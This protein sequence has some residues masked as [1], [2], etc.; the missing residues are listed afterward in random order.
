MRALT[1]AMTILAFPWGSA[2]A[3]EGA[4]ADGN[5]A[6]KYWQAFATLPKFTDAENKKISECVSTPLDHVTSKML[7]DAEYSFQMLHRGASLRRCDWGMSYEQGIYARFPHT[8]AARV[9]TSLAVLR[10]RMRFAAGQNAEATSDLL[11][12]MT[13]GRHISVD[14]SIITVLVGYQ[15]DNRI[16][17][18][19]AQN[20]PKL[21]AKSI[22]D[23]KNRLDALPSFG[24]MSAALLTCEKETMEW[25]IRTVKGTKDRESLLALL[26]VISMS[27]GKD[28]DPNEVARALLQECGGTSEGVIKLAQAVLPSYDSTAKMLDLPSS[29]FAKQFQIASTKQAGN[30]IYKVFFPA[31]AKVHQSM[32]R[33]EVRR[34]LLSAAIAVHLNGPGALKDHPDPAS[35]GPF[36]YSKFP[37]GFELRSKSSGQQDKPVSLT[38]GHRG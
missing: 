27:E 25:F 26:S 15:I 22:T 10:G 2:F 18:T 23:L 19:L 38:V 4:D 3:N 1:L 16:S 34:A 5:A 28:H 8:D 30:P 24:T 32:V 33:T 13:L 12:A 7:A 11:A 20:L 35:G 36:D 9:L 29:E 31:I 17:E 6:L 37:G 21:D 14:G